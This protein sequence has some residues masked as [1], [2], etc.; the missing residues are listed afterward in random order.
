MYA[1]KEERISSAKHRS[2][3]I[4]ATKCTIH[5]SKVKLGLEPFTQMFPETNATSASFT[6]TNSTQSLAGANRLG[7]FGWTNPALL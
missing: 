3:N 7:L 4:F 6:R 5:S 1:C 2:L